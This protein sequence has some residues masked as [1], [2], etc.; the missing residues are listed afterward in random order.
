MKD[1]FEQNTSLSIKAIDTELGESDG[2]KNRTATYF[3]KNPKNNIRMISEYK[4]K[5]ESK[6]CFKNS[7]D[8][9]VSGSTTF[10]HTKGNSLYKN[11]VLTNL[12]NY[13]IHK[14]EFT[15][16]SP[17]NKMSPISK[18]NYENN[19]P[20]IKRNLQLTERNIHSKMCT[21]SAFSYKGKIKQK[22]KKIPSFESDSVERPVVVKKTPINELFDEYFPRSTNNSN[23]K[24]RNKKIIS[25]TEEFIKKTKQHKITEH[26]INLKDKGIF[27]LSD[28]LGEI[29]EHLKRHTLDLAEKS[30]KTKEN[31]TNFQILTSL[32]NKNISDYTND[33]IDK[34]KVVNTF[35]NKL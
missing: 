9:T 35:I 34:I 15:F 32:E 31:I 12:S 16:K 14:K 30:L 29:R 18:R 10:Y 1:N 13:I 27:K 19:L 23:S 6:K 26:L 28:N 2:F 22:I 17:D 4:N 33:L 11:R 24:N 7:A 3:R 25:G 5:N 21:I 8:E 20:S